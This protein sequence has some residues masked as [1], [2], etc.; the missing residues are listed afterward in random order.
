M[1]EI[2]KSGIYLSI[3]DEGRMGYAHYGVPRSGAMDQYS[4]SMANYI[5]GNQSDAAVLE[6]TMGACRLLFHE[7]T[8][9]CLSGAYAKAELDDSQI[10]YHK[11][12]KIK[13]G[14]IL[15]ISKVNYG[16]RTYLAVKGGFLT[17]SILGSRSMY[18]PITKSNRLQKA[19]H[20]PY[21]P[22]KQLALAS[23]VVKINKEHF[24]SSIIPCMPG[25]EYESLNAMQRDELTANS[26][27][28][29]T[30]NSRMGYKLD[31]PIANN[32]PSMLTSA[33]LP[34]TVQL[35]PSGT[36]IVVMRDG[37]VTGGYPRVLQL[38]D[39]A[40][41]RMAQKGTHDEIRFEIRLF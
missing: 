3:Q 5:L 27:K 20:I 36:L 2:V 14:Q 8:Y 17:E 39:I 38:T 1:L 31:H 11:I 13:K 41:N 16:V 9:I 34:G 28:I 33:V 22:T 6:I 35:T 23:A 12:I 32:L 18:A 26:F 4:A 40:I 25:P 15:Q 37:Q 30:A 19:D 7:E 21:E 10:D 29:T 24:D